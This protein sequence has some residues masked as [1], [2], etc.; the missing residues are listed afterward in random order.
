[1][2]YSIPNPFQ[3]TCYIAVDYPD[4]LNPTVQIFSLRGSRVRKFETGDII[5]QRIY[6]DGKDEQGREV[7]SGIYFVL[8][9]DNSFE[10][11]GKIARQR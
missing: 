8:L 6:W 11:L 4:T 3:T 5:N 10:K 9:K 1:M 2:P 7:G